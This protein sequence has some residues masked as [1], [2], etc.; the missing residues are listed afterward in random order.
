MTAQELLN[1]SRLLRSYDNRGDI[2][3]E[4]YKAIRGFESEDAPTIHAFIFESD[5]K[6]FRYS[7]NALKGDLKDALELERDFRVEG[8]IPNDIQVLLITKLNSQGDFNA[9]A[10]TKKL[11]SARDITLRDFVLA[12]KAFADDH[13]PVENKNEAEDVVKQIEAQGRSSNPDEPKGMSRE[14][15]KELDNELKEL[16]NLLFIKTAQQAQDESVKVI[17]KGLIDDADEI[18]IACENIIEMMEGAETYGLMVGSVNSINLCCQDI[19][20]AYNRII[21]GGRLQNAGFFNSRWDCQYKRIDDYTRF[22]S[23][24]VRVAKTARVG[25]DND[26]AFKPAMLN[27]IKKGAETIVKVANSLINF[28]NRYEPFD[29]DRKGDQ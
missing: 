25:D 1:K 27:C 6:G 22:L 4:I 8:A 17:Y 2:Q 28:C 11:G 21:G 23:A 12:L 19:H 15:L 13:K 29:F 9:F 26:S 7:H 14:Q 10:M 18:I 3:T 24:W 5:G 20:N 16:Q